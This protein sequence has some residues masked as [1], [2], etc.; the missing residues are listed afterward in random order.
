MA[1]IDQNGKL[2]FCRPSQIDHYEINHK[3]EKLPFILQG[4]EIK[5]DYRPRSDD[6]GKPYYWMGLGR[7]GEIDPYEEHWGE[8]AYLVA[9]AWHYAGRTDAALRTAAD[10]LV[11]GLRER[12]EAGQLRSF[13]WQ[14]RSAVQAPA[15]LR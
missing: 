9:M 13:N 11:T 14:C 4:R 7:A 6:E 12:G 2:N 5:Q 3:W 10:E 8:S 15:Y 1:S